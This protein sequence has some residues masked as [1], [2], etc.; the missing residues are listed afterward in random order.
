MIATRIGWLVLEAVMIG[1]FLYFG[2]GAAFA[3]A[4]AM[5]LIPI[6]TL[7]LSLYLRN[8]IKMSVTAEPNVRKGDSGGFVITLENPTPWPVMRIRCRVRTENQLNREEE[9]FVINTWLPPKGSQ[10]AAASVG[11]SYCG[12]IKI[13]VDKMMLT[14]CFGLISIGY[15][16]NEA[17]YI[18]VQP[19]T[20][21]MEV[22]LRPDAGANDESDVY[23]E[24][25]P[26]NDMTETFQIREYVPGDSMR[27]I[28][29]KL[30]NKFDRLIV[31]DP[32]LP[33]I[34]N[35]LIFWERSGENG[36]PDIIDA[37]AEIIV[38]LC[39]SLLENSIQFTVGWNDT[40]RNLCILH[41]IRDTEELVGIIP[42][43]MR[44]TGSPSGVT[45]TELLIQTWEDAL[46]GHMVYLAQNPGQ[47]VE[48]LYDYGSVAMV[49]GGEN[50]V[51]GARIFDA[52][53]YREQL[54]QIDI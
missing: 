20:F 32:S 33:V 12:R 4:A 1:Y 53:N 51:D 40:D 24:Q 44:A 48:Q 31:R 14:D 10:Q 11:S 18:T 13:S 43:L 26:G 6:L 25:K 28:H 15:K 36:D 38:T 3:L 27:Q 22:S 34:R 41:E 37:Q 19:D 23:S 29:W 54:S 7:P 9:F 42:R 47:G 49:L 46:C 45:G 16:P 21:E 8:K 30:S 52:V 39:K 17:A 2:S 5:I 50:S 35:V